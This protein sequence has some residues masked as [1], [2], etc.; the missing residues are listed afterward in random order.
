MASIS[1]FSYSIDMIE[2]LA[3]S[4][5]NPIRIGQFCGTHC[6]LQ[7]TT[8]R[9]FCSHNMRLCLMCGKTWFRF[10]EPEDHVEAKQTGRCKEDVDSSTLE[11][12]Q[13]MR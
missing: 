12:I 2:M 9:L 13:H 6:W 1:S 10:Q 7:W 4:K 11:A 5:E 3:K 8:G